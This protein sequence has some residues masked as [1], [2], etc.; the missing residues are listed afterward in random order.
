MTPFFV[1]QND[2]DAVLVTY[3]DNGRGGMSLDA[4]CGEDLLVVKICK[5]E[6]FHTPL[7]IN[8]VHLKITLN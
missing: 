5:P 3:H 8:M 4:A 1:R 6:M 7:K 2:Y